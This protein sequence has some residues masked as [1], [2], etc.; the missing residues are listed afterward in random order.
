MARS[1]S[2]ADFELYIGSI[3][4]LTLLVSISEAGFGKYGLKIVPVYLVNNER[5]L[6]AGYLRF[7][8]MGCLLLSVLIGLTAA[9]IEAW[10]RAGSS[11]SV[12]L[13]AMFFLPAMALSGVAIDLLLAFQKPL[14]A[15]IIARLLVPLISLCL[16]GF[17]LLFGS[18]TPY[19]AVACFGAGGLA[20]VVAAF[21]IGWKRSAKSVDHAMRVMNHRVWI[22]NGVSFFAF[23]LVSAWFFKAT[24]F[25]LHH[26]PHSGIELAMLAPAFETGC[27]I[28]LLSKSTDKFFQPSMAITLDQKDWVRADQIRNQRYAVVGVGVALFLLIIF[29]FGDQILG[30]YGED[31]VNATASL[32]VIAIGASIWTLFSLAPTFLLFADRRT[33]LF[34]SMLVHAV[35]LAV[36]TIGLFYR[37]GG[38]GA[39]WAFALTMSSLAICNLVLA[40]LEIK[41]LQQS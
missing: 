31:F 21:F 41:R 5:K 18:L 13:M 38:I 7:A 11:E 40:Q 22:K 29:Q 15:T 1:L 16:T 17:L 20:G 32:R 27:L 23:G 35:A 34:L 6:L 30:W 33:T 12:I 14:A 39:A 26:V 25:L 37:Y 24:L 2:H 19:L 3:A 28:L 9:G 4:T 8:L 10:L 36:L